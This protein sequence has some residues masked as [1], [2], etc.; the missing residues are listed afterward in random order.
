MHNEDKDALIPHH[1]HSILA[2]EKIA[3]VLPSYLT[4]PDVEQNA[5]SI[6]HIRRKR[7]M[8][9]RPLFV[10]RK[11][12]EEREYEEERE[13]RRLYSRKYNMESPDSDN[14]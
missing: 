4:N 8:A 13:E 9:F 14:F 12:A 7:Y 3:P 2:S 10:Y 1:E 6:S 5:A 11:L